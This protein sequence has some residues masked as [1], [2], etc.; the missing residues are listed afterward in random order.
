MHIIAIEIDAALARRLF[1]DPHNWNDKDKEKLLQAI[2]Y[3]LDN[4]DAEE[5]E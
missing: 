3:S 1:D 4:D 2:E 5:E